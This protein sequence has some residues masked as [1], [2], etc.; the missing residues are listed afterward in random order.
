MIDV[1]ELNRSVREEFLRDGFYFPVTIYGVEEAGRLYERYRQQ[2]ESLAGRGKENPHLR[3]RWIFDITQHPRILDVVERILGRDIYCMNSR[4][5]SK[6]PAEAAFVSWH[7]DS[8][9]SGLEDPRDMIT[10][11][12][13]F[14]DVT[15]LSGPVR[16][17]PGSQREGQRAHEDTYAPENML[18]RGQRLLCV[19]ESKT[20]DVLL[21]SGQ[22]SF[23]H[24]YVIHGSAPNRS[25]GPRVGLGIQYMAARAKPVESFDAEP[26]LVRGEDRY[27]HFSARIAQVVR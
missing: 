19:D 22:A 18:T 14:T 10:A 24:S 7:Q 9:Y 5:F 13:A 25:S 2:T 3:E 17:V 26:V 11:W 6:E 4:F 12:V 20:V 15:A 16:M 21:K 23:H 27:G 1:S 8:T